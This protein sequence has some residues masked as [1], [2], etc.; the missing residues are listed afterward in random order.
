MN[1]SDVGFRDIMGKI[2]VKWM[3]LTGGHRNLTGGAVP[4][5]LGY[6]PVA[7]DVGSTG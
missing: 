6:G 5:P 1:V 4:P 7:M 3:C 2:S